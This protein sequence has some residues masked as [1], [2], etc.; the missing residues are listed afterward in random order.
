MA[1]TA[2][3]GGDHEGADWIISSNT[4]VGG[5]HT[6]IGR[7]EVQSG[8]IATV[9]LATAFQ[10]QARDVLVIGT[11]N[12]DGAGYFG[13]TGG[14]GVYAGDCGA[15]SCPSSCTGS[16]SSGNHGTDGSGPYGGVKGAPGGN[17]G[18]NAAA[19]NGDF[20][21]DESV[22]FGSGGGGGKAGNSCVP[23]CNADCPTKCGCAPNPTDNHC[24]GGTGGPHESPSLCAGGGAVSLIAA[25]YMSVSGTISAKG[26]G[27]V[28]GGSGESDSCGYGQE[29]Y[30]SGRGAGGGI[31][32]KC[33]GTGGVTVT[34]TLDTRGGGNNTTIYGTTKV[35][36]LP[37]R[38]SIGSATKYTGHAGSGGYGSPYT[39]ETLQETEGHIL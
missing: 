17:G 19:A 16:A 8:R 10:V 23:N 34:G 22:T 38:I 12:A 29:G 18:Y 35:F 37:G 13:G 9:Q 28:S 1:W 3:G 39:S 6:N 5:T 21:T 15:G 27:T 32:L 7:F 30:S 2:T 33:T 4:T 36:A 26:L 14:S 24:R 25:N 20:S 11:I 31:L